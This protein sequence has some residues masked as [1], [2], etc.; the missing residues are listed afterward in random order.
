MLAP[1]GHP[2]ESVAPRDVSM[3]TYCLDTPLASDKDRWPPVR[4]SLAVGQ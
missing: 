2:Q 4:G 3:G 1:P